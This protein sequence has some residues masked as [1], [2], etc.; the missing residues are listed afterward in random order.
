M[1]I[2]NELIIDI[3]RETSELPQVHLDMP[4]ASSTGDTS[5]ST[6]D[7]FLDMFTKK[8]KFLSKLTSFDSEVERIFDSNYSDDIILILILSSSFKLIYSIINVAI[9]PQGRGLLKLIKKKEKNTPPPVL[10]QTRRI[11]ITFNRIIHAIG[12]TVFLAQFLLQ[13]VTKKK[14]KKKQYKCLTFNC[15]VQTHTCNVFFRVGGV[16][17][18][19]AAKLYPQMEVALS[20]ILL[21][22]KHTKL[23]FEAPCLIARSSKAM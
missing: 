9:I 22:A 11:I 6:T 3:F 21:F 23:P 7:I 15:N 18:R 14:E 17:E 10:K 12:L 5:Q 20:L 1:H 2:I 19:E 8:G 4:Q 16:A 13:S